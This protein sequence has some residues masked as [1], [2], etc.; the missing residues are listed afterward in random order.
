RTGSP[1]IEVAHEALLREWARLRGWIDAAREDVRLH[2]R[3]SAAAAEWAESG[4]DQSFLPRGS[5]LD[6]LASATGT[7]GLALTDVERSFLAA[8]LDQRRTEERAERERVEQKLRQNRRLRIAV[9]VI[10]V[11]LAAAIVAGLA[12]FRAQDRE[13]E[14]R[15]VAE[16]GRLGALGLLEDQLDRSLLLAREGVGI[17]DSLETRSNLLAALLRSPAAIGATR[18]NGDVVRWLDL[19]ADGR[20]LAAGF[21]DGRVFLLDVRRRRQVGSPIRAAA[22]DVSKVE[23]SPDGSLLAVSSLEGRVGLWETRTQALRHRLQRPEGLLCAAVAFSPNGQTV[24]GLFV[25]EAAYFAPVPGRAVIVRW[26]A[27][28]GR[29]VGSPVQVSSRGGDFMYYTSDGERLVVVN[30]AGVTVVDARTPRRVA[31]FPHGG[32]PR[33]FS[34]S[35]SPRDPQLVALLSVTEGTV[36]FL[37]L[38]TGK[39][40]QAVGGRHTEEAERI[41][42]SPDGRTLATSAADGKVIV[43]DVKSGRARETFPGHAGDVEGLAFSADSRTLYSGAGSRIIAWDLGGSRRL[44]RPFRFSPSNL[45]P[46]LLAVAVSP[47]G[48]RI[49]V[50]SGDRADR[51]AFLDIATLRR[52]G[53]AFSP[54]VGAIA[55]LRFSPDGRSLAVGGKADDAVLIDASSGATMRRFARGHAGGVASIRFSPDGRRLLTGGVADGRAIIWE[56]RTGRRIRVLDEPGG[57]PTLVDWSEDGSMVATAGSFH[58]ESDGTVVVW[59]TADWS[60]VATLEA[61]SRYSLAVDFSP[62]GATISTAGLD[63][64]VRLWDIETAE[65]FGRPLVHPGFAPSVEFDR[66]G[67]TLVTSSS[68]G[69]VRL[70]DA[71]SRRQIGSALPG[72]GFANRAGFTPD[73]KSVVVVYGAGVGLLWE[74]DP[75]RWKARACAV[76]GRSLTREEWAEFLPDRAYEPACA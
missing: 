29:R 18:L 74:V 8:G 51:V 5:Q 58:P 31:T 71:K 57:Q 7:G 64:I 25:E 9:G 45:H 16:A 2:R 60:K 48:S 53:T 50:A 1:T 41:R 19:T 17:H 75:E 14:A 28:T 55:T 76:A 36:E 67:E 39:R 10:A 63:G 37:D 22:A 72:S 42:F 34:I 49:A 13:A 24:A 4:R 69:N 21:G 56:V 43:W 54:G 35:V 15:S 65:P 52:L 6:Q 44:G 66:T 23:F 62:D 12:A 32:R 61:D 59:R 26:D 73:G 70:W 30:H 68:D 3:L 46:S 11:A 33:F 20:L 47:D 27:S 38:A 40:R